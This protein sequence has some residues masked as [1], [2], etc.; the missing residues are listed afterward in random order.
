MLNWRVKIVDPVILNV[1]LNT[2]RIRCEQR[3]GYFVFKPG[4]S[5]ET[6]PYKKCLKQFKIPNIMKDYVGKDV[7]MVRNYIDPEP[8]ELFRM[9]L[10][11]SEVIYDNPYFTKS[12]LR[13]PSTYIIRYLD[14]RAPILNMSMASN[15][16]KNIEEGTLNLIMTEQRTAMYSM[17]KQTGKSLSIRLLPGMIKFMEHA[18]GHVTDYE[19]VSTTEK[20]SNYKYGIM[21]FKR[22]EGGGKDISTIR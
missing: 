7:K 3:N 22:R 12:Y 2:E 13:L 5:I 11:G 4:T 14:E 10:I 16:Y 1:M 15:T 17:I 19:Y 18:G 8:N 9:E 21:I 20:N 6:Y